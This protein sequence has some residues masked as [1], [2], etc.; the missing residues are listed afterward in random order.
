MVAFINPLRLEFSIL[1]L[2]TP[3]NLLKPANLNN[4]AAI[5]FVLPKPINPIVIAE[6]FCCPSFPKQS[7]FLVN[8]P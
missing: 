6:I 1:S 7:T 8:C 3:M 4:C 2:S 5:L